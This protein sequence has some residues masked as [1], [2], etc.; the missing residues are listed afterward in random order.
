MGA[1]AVY[2]EKKTNLPEINLVGEVLRYLTLRK[3][4]LRFVLKYVGFNN[5]F[6]RTVLLFNGK[7]YG[8][9]I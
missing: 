9:D 6:G 3:A 5:L 7:T 1:V 2:S 8:T 4:V